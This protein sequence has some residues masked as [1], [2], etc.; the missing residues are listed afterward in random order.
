[1][2]TI[3]RLLLA[4]LFKK[5]FLQ[6]A[7]IDKLIE[8]L[9]EFNLDEEKRV[10]KMCKLGIRKGLFVTCFYNYVGFCKLTFKGCANLC[11]D[12]V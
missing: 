9:H 1:M 2:S 5:S 12:C 11:I 3:D 7:Q 8:S 6:H 4:K 10:S